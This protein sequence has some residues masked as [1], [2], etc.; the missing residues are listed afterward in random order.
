[1]AA[2]TALF[3]TARQRATAAS[4]L[5]NGPVKVSAKLP[6]KAARR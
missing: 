6:A 3:S 1:V 4:A 5:K 2:V